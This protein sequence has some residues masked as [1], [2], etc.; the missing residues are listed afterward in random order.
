MTAVEQLGQPIDTKEIECRSLVMKLTNWGLRSGR[1]EVPLFS[2]AGNSAAS[3]AQYSQECFL[4]H[5]KPTIQSN[6]LLPHQLGWAANGA[7]L[8]ISLA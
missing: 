7:C 3:S 1:S 8:Q 5:K 4:Y 2:S 6:P